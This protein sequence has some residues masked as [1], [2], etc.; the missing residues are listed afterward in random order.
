[1]KAVCRANELSGNTEFIIATPN[2]AFQ[3]VIYAK[4]RCDYGYRLSRAFVAE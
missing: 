1:M 4:R 3:N 2:G